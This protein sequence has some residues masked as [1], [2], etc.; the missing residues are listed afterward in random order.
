M[1]DN[2]NPFICNITDLQSYTEFQERIFSLWSLGYY[3][4]CLFMG[5]AQN[6]YCGMAKDGEKPNVLCTRVPESRAYPSLSRISL[7]FISW[8]V[9]Y[10]KKPGLYLWG[11]PG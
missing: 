11:I 4:L 2:H 7:L 3:P 1:E 6:L 10:G 9:N 8:S 5:D